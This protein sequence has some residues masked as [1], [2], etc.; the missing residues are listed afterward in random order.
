MNEELHEDHRA[1]RLAKNRFVVML[2][3]SIGVALLLVTI[4]MALYSSSGTAQLD[5]SRPGYAG[6]SSKINSDQSFTTFPNTGEINKETL[7]SFEKLYDETAKQ[8]SSTN[9]FESSVLS[10]EA[11]RINDNPAA[12]ANQ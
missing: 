6:I 3:C 10:D 7:D 5:L 11:L 12:T 1:Y 4:S 9:A 2:L 8:A